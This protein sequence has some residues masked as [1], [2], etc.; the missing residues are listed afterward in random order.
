ME[1][2]PLYSQGIFG[3]RESR[4]RNKRQFDIKRFKRDSGRKSLRYR[5]SLLW[6]AIDNSLKSKE[7]SQEFKKN[8]KLHI[9]FINNFSFKSET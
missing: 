4:A 2:A 6:N 7:N 1:T 3:K 8:I 5:G 9:D